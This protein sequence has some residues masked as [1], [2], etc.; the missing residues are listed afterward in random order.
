MKKLSVITG[1]AGAIGRA[2]AME[3]GKEGV[4]VIGDMLEENIESTQSIL[5]SLNIEHHSMVMDV[6]DKQSCI[7][8]AAFASQYG[9]ISNFI[10]I[11]GVAP[12]TTYKETTVST[13]QEIFDTNCVGALNTMEAFLPYLGE[14][15]VSIQT[16]SQASYHAQASEPIMNIYK[17]CFEDGFID[18]L[19]MLTASIEEPERAS[20]SAY[21]LSKLFVIELCKASMLRFAKKG[22]RIVS[23]SPGPHWTRHVWELSEEIQAHVKRTAPLGCFGRTTDLGSVYAFLCSDAAQYITG[24]DILVDGGGIASSSSWKID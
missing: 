7:D 3:L 11:A 5:T 24:V 13:P 2:V 16:A 18:R 17:S 8:F 22:A 9:A 1:G 6:R 23:V 14:G 19:C 10:N 21:C 20:G 12:N 4:V 15:S